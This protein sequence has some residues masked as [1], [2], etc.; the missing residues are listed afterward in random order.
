MNRINKNLSNKNNE[1]NDL[2]IQAGKVFKEKR[3]T[4]SLS[5]SHLS[6]KTKISVT[7]IEAIENG[8]IEQLPERAYLASMLKILANELDIENDLF[9]KLSKS[10]QTKSI[11]SKNNSSNKL[12][13]TFLNTWQGF[14]IHSICILSSI[15]LLNRMNVIISIN[16]ANTVS[17]IL[18]DRSSTEDINLKE[19]N[20]K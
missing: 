6:I 10:T 12:I 7:V 2:F 11:K 18:F 19:S 20:K 4:K 9:N 8:W 3:E 15:F 13:S 1:T 14:F 5:R 16:N 17:P